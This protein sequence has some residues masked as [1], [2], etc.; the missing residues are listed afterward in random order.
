MAKTLADSLT[1]A[2][3]GLER[4]RLNVWEWSPLY[5]ERSESI[6]VCTDVMSYAVKPFFRMFYFIYLFCVLVL[7]FAQQFGVHV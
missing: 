2:P 5:T 6:Y 7:R 1:K 3:T 4:G